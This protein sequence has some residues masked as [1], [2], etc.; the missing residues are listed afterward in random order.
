MDAA[1]SVL[2]VS[3]ILF[4]F[5]FAGFWWS[6]NRELKFPPT[7]RHFKLSYA[8]L[9]LGMGILGYFGIIAPLRGL[10]GGAAGGV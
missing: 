9:V 4:G 1:A 10:A 7:E 3:S 6:L 5:L 8:L 2:T